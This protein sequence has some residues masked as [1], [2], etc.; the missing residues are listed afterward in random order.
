MNDILIIQNPDLPVKYYNNNGQIH[1]IPAY[2]YE[3]HTYE[4]VILSVTEGQP[5]VIYDGIRYLD[6]DW[7]AMKYPKFQPLVN[8]ARRNMHSSDTKIYI[9]TSV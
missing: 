6:G 9:E 1:L 7:A 2:L 8:K 3:E 5:I 4:L